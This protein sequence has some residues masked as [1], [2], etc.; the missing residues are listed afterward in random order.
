MLSDTQKVGL[1]TELLDHELSEHPL[2][3]TCERDWT[4]E[5]KASDGTLLAK[6]MSATDAQSFISLAEGRQHELD[7]ICAEVDEELKTS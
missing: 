5:V 2:P 1:L 3:W 4:Y 7:N 6:F